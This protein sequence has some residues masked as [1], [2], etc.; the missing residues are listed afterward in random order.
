MITLSL[1]YRCFQTAMV[2]SIKI[3]KMLVRPILIF[4]SI[5]LSLGSK[6]IG[7]DCVAI[8]FSRL[9]VYTV[10]LSEPTTNPLFVSRL[11][12]GTGFLWRGF[13]VCVK[14]KSRFKLLA[15]PM[16]IHLRVKP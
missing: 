9:I 10:V 2:A 7:V 4:I 5:Y 15:H 3:N 16:Y 6:L 11:W 14:Q 1:T 12:T 8:D 13:G